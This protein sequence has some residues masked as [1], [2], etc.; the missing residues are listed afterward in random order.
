MRNEKLFIF[1]IIIIS[2]VFY[3]IFPSFSFAQS[4]YVLPYPSS[5]PGNK[6]YKVRLVYEEIEKYWYF[7]DFGKF[8][9]SLKQS[10]KYLVEAKTLFEY[11]QYL[12]A[13]GSLQKSDLYFKNIPLVLKEA[14]KKNKNIDQKQN[15]LKNASLKHIEVLDT[16][17]NFTPDSFVWSPEK[18]LP[19]NLNIK[20]AID[21]SVR[22]RE[23][24]IN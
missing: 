5:M 2:F 10:D 20:K 1:L 8:K 22:I 14:R 19:I 17:I 16:I 23:K 3:S 12:L 9:Y 18:S 11:K 21:E 7:G 6:L 15:L 4:E 13:Y 24:G